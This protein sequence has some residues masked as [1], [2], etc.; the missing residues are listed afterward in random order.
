[1]PPT[2][3]PMK[4]KS[5]DCVPLCYIIVDQILSEIF[6]IAFYRI[7]W[8]QLCVCLQSPNNYVGD[9]RT[10]LYWKSD[11]DI[12]TYNIGSPPL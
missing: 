4:Y 5:Q 12:P 10:P 9:C 6:L 11:K 7:E 8:Q 2:Y 1:M 3:F